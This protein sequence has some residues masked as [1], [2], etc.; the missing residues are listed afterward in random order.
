MKKPEVTNVVISYECDYEPCFTTYSIALKYY[1]GELAN[2]V[3]GVNY[4]TQDDQNKNLF[5]AKL[6]KFIKFIDENDERIDCFIVTS[7]HIESGFR[8]NDY[9]NIRLTLTKAYTS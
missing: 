7:K 9:Y 5:P 4:I 8:V 1:N 3:M 2:Q 6:W